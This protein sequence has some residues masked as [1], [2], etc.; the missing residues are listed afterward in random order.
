MTQLLLHGNPVN[1]V[2]DLLGKKEN[3]L[4][5]SLGWALA[6]SPMFLQCLLDDIFTTA[7]EYDSTVRLQEYGGK[8]GGFTDIEIFTGEQT[9]V[10]EAKRGWDLPTESQLRKYLPRLNLTGGK[11]LVV[12]ECTES[13]AK[14]RLPNALDGVPIEYWR[15]HRFVEEAI[16]SA[17]KTKGIREKQLLRQLVRYLK[18]VMTIQD[19]ESNRVYVVSLSKNRFESS[20]LH[21]DTVVMEK[22]RYFHPVGG[23]K[24]GWPKEP[25]NYLGFR[26]DGKLQ[27]VSHVEDYTIST[28]PHD[29]I[30]E[31]EDHVDWSDEPH[32]IYTLGPNMVP[33][34]EVRTGKIY[35]SHRVWAALDL[36]LTSDT[37]S[38]ARDKTVERLTGGLPE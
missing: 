7:P 15:W 31:I 35:R 10:V 36:L 33:A 18:G 19:V 29:E 23:K 21:F 28:H 5:Y 9:L 27:R 14:D 34:H 3:D 25:P 16:T 17:D 4:T 30:P 22:H 37:I 20:T 12:S 24:G 8:G 2:F 38:E 6:E 11:I 13:F 32:F 26:F 1:T